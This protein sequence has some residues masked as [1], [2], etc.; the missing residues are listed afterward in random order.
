[1]QQ[2]QEGAQPTQVQPS[3]P[4]RGPFPWLRVIVAFFFFSVLALLAILALLATG[5]VI[6]STWLI[7]APSLTG[8]ITAFIPVLTW[9]FPQN[10]SSSGTGTTQP[11]PVSDPPQSS[12]ASDATSGLSTQVPPSTSQRSCR[13]RQE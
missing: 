12:P 4:P 13:T 5:H 6:D 8:V 10:S 7:V 1:V 11:P 9:L 2:Q 3:R